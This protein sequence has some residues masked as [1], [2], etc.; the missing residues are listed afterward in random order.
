M[1]PTF[2]LALNKESFISM[3][4]DLTQA[5]VE[6]YTGTIVEHVEVNHQSI[7]RMEH[8]PEGSLKYLV[9]RIEACLKKTFFV[10]YNCHMLN[11]CFFE[12]PLS[13]NIRR[14]HMMSINVWCFYFL[15]F[16]YDLLADE[17]HYDTCNHKACCAQRCSDSMELLSH[18]YKD[19]SARIE[20]YLNCEEYSSED[21]GT[22]IIDDWV[23]TL[24]LKCH[25][26]QYC[27]SHVDDVLQ[28]SMAAALQ[29]QRGTNW[30]GA[31]QMFKVEDFW[32]SAREPPS[33]DLAYK[34]IT[35]S[36]KQSFSPILYVWK[37][38]DSSYYNDRKRKCPLLRCCFFPKK[39]V[40][41]EGDDSMEGQEV[42]PSIG[43]EEAI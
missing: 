17:A 19:E 8:L 29:M 16:H 22:Y 23:R 3:N 43:Q 36:R 32:R 27:E 26:C 12:F 24:Q 15:K 7:V 40:R 2:I 41:E 11:R 39:Q 4:L 33:L 13:R 10:S 21:F 38:R 1:Y 30:G 37:D 35:F 34:W 14:M 18:W 6:P 20:L 25:V 9:N 42:E 28:H 5:W 31:I